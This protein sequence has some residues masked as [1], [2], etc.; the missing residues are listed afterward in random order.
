MSSLARLGLRTTAAA[1]GIAAIGAGLAGHAFAAPTPGVPAL[2]GAP[3][4]NAGSLSNIGSVPNVVG[5]LPA[6]PSSLSELPQLFTFEGPTFN[7]A[8][9]AGTGL[10]ELPT[11]AA[12]DGLARA[13]GGV[14][15]AQAGLNQAPAAGLGP[16]SQLGNGASDALPVVGSAGPLVDVAQKAA[17]GELS[18]EGNTID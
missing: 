6:P 5:E 10:P 12:G 7:T 4:P 3:L 2:P 15:H 18:T 8:G 1:A 9:P 17:A 11:T 16:L 14:E 13:E